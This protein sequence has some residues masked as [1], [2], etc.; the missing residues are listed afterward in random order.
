MPQ[1]TEAVMELT[2]TIWDG[3]DYVPQV[4]ADWL[5]D[6]QG[7]LMV[8][9]SDGRVVGLAHLVQL[10]DQ[11]WWLEGIRVHPQFEGRRIASQ[12]HDYLLEYWLAHGAGAL[13]LA[14]HSHRTA[15]HR[16]C[17]RT[18]FRKICE[19]SFFVAPVIPEEENNAGGHPEIPASLQ[20]LALDEIPQAVALARRSASLR[21]TAGLIDLG[22]RNAPPGE[23]YFAWAVEQGRAWRRRDR[24]ALLLVSPEDDA[25]STGTKTPMLML[26]ACQPEDAVEMLL[27]YRRLGAV[28]GYT[29]VTWAAPLHPELLPILEAA[30]FM[31]DWEDAIFIYERHHP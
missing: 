2:S 22:W 16:I 13:R 19:C 8:A 10:S 28:L 11:D 15:I 20:P 1:D 29:K 23:A 21:W 18:G 9:E 7:L 6:P 24:E 5:A 31:R 4:W 14:T 30:G 17:D 3:D 25:D 26:L 12:M 27:D